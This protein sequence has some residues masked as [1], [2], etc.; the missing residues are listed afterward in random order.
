MN[1]FAERLKYLREECGITQKELAKICKVSPQCICSLEQ[2]TRR[3]TGTT[4]AELA[5]ALN[6]SA[7]YL[8][9]L[10]NDFGS[11][12]FPRTEGAEISVKTEKE[13]ALLCAFKKL[14]SEA[15]DSVLNTAQ[16]LAQNKR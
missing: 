15:Q 2:N 1:G 14:S 5:R 11:K 10:E 6:V 13:K 3:P 12:T 7:D 9:G 4:V 8:L 16:L